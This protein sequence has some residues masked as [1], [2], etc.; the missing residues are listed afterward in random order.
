MKLSVFIPC[1]T[2]QFKPE[3]AQNLFKVLRHLGV[4]VHYPDQQT[5]CGLVAY[6]A[7]HWDEAR[8]IGEKF[9]HEF[10]SD[11]YV[12][13]SSAACANMVKHNY[14]RFFYN[15]SFHLEYKKLQT[16]V[17][18]LS[19]FLINVLHVSAWK[20]KFKAKVMLHI[21]S[22]A[23]IDYHLSDEPLQLLKMIEGVT[24]V[25]PAHHKSGCG[26]GGAFS[27]MYSELSTDFALEELNQAIA[28]GAE[29]IITIETSCVLQLE[30]VAIKH[31]LDIKIMTL[32]DLLAES[33]RFSDAIFNEDDQ[34]AIG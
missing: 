5:C 4:E 13:M 33:L 15:T 17:F 16:R 20:G 27:V 9:I 14:N 31:G 21:E 32:P 8:F 12:V 30:S 3:S 7:G 29:Y 24:L 11:H 2:D 22:S 10:A 26:F 34:M 19:D 6:N 23:V 1:L 28:A 25:E 18:E